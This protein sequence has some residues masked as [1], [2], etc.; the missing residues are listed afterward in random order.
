MIETLTRIGIAVALL[1]G[2][3][4]LMDYFI[5]DTTWFQGAYDTVFP[6]MFALSAVPIFDTLLTIIFWVSVF[7]GVYFGFKLV[8]RFLHWLDITG[9]PFLD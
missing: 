1:A 8:L 9:A 7:E 2:V 5:V 6:A 3:Q 4:F